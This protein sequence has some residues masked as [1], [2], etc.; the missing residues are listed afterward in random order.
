MSNDIVTVAQIPKKDRR[1]LYYAATGLA[2]YPSSMSKAGLKR[3]SKAGLVDSWKRPTEAKLTPLG[4]RLAAEAG[5]HMKGNG[6]QAPLFVGSPGADAPAVDV[7][8]EPAALILAE[9]APA[10]P[11]VEARSPW[12]WV[13]G[14]GRLLPEIMAAM[15]EKFGRLLVPFVG[16]G[17]LV[18][19]MPGRVAYISDANSHLI[20]AYTAIR[21]R[22][23]DLI[24]ALQDHKNDRDYYDSVVESF[25]D[26]YGDDIW[27]AAAFMYMNKVGFN[28]LCRYN[29]KG[30]YNVPFGDNPKATICDADNMRACSAALQ[31]VE[32]VIEDFRAVEERAR[33][34]DLVY[35]DCPYIQ[36]SK[37]AAFTGYWGKWTDRDHEDVPALFRRLASRGVHG[38]ASNSDTPKVR[39]L[40]AG[41]EMR[42]LTRANSINSKASAR[43]GKTEI[44]VLGGTWTPRGAS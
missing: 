4:T 39:E 19:A 5:W 15:P 38:L 40:Y 10:V 8:T 30:G 27:R 35:L 32:I 31:G 44:L 43:G 1:T 23:D 36:E 13:G 6:T 29:L 28:G 22:V 14:K 11:V 34:G 24:L 41:F 25:N 26:G 33:P 12:K 18:F 9:P 7:T 3:L 20:N 37:T 21:D 42:T 17:A 2:D 16:G